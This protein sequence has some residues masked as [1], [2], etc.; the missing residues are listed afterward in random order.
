LQVIAVNLLTGPIARALAALTAV[1]GT[2]L[3]VDVIVA[4]IMWVIEALLERATGHRVEYQ[5]ALAAGATQALPAG[6]TLRT[7]YD[8]KLPI[9]PAPGKVLAKPAP[10]PKLPAGD[11]PAIPAGPARPAPTLSAPNPVPKPGAFGAAPARPATA[12]GTTS[13]VTGT[14]PPISGPPALARPQTPAPAKPN[15][16]AAPGGNNP[17]AARPA[18]SPFGAAPAR[19]A[20][21]APK[22][23]FGSSADDEDY[24][25]AD[26][27][28]EEDDGK[29]PPSNKDD[30]NADLRY[31][32]DEDA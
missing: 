23:R 24:I 21:P 22:P 20:A 15:L 16:P 14:K 28:D 8:L 3:I 31:V 27:I 2:V 7:V 25:D 26:V 10:A 9:P 4:I 11:R 29:K 18:G 19:P 17:P 13:G 12:T 6:T 30:D 32:D 5:P 1:F